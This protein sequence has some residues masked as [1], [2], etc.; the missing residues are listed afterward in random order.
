M[1]TREPVSVPK[2][3]ADAD[4]CPSAL[5][6]G[7]SFIRVGDSVASRRRPVARIQDRL[8]GNNSVARGGDASSSYV[9]EMISRNVAWSET[10]ITG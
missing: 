8:P 9:L 2:V 1:E 5:T 4:G 6:A 7:G 10:P 3:R